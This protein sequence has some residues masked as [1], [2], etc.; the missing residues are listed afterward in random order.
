MK[1]TIKIKV[2]DDLE[3]CLTIDEA[4]QLYSKLQEL[5]GT[6]IQPF[7]TPIQPF[8]TPPYIVTC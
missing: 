7:I 1:T 6:P 2:N 4:K 5:F 8:I 3:L